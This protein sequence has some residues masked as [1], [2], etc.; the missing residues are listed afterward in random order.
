ML[1]VMIEAFIMVVLAFLLTGSRAVFF[2]DLFRINAVIDWCPES[3]IEL[4]GLPKTRL[5]EQTP[6]GYLVQT[7]LIH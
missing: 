4:L 1:H 7:F 6:R 3:E 2:C 5:L